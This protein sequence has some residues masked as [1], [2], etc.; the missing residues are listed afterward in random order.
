MLRGQ[1]PPR[2]GN[3]GVPEHTLNHQRGISAPG[4]LLGITIPSRHW[5]IAERAPQT[6][7]YLGGRVR[8]DPIS[9]IVSLYHRTEIAFSAGREARPSK[10][11]RDIQNPAGGSE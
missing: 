7:G 1:N 8:F 10:A 6:G 11:G 9:K 2:D 4:I 5:F 3:S